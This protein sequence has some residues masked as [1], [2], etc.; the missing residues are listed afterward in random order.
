MDLR[1]LEYFQMVCRLNNMT[2]A[3][4]RLYVAQP[5]ISVAIHKLEVEMGVQ[6]FERSQKQFTL[7]AEGRIFLQRAEDILHRSQ[8]LLLE[9]NEYRELKKGVVKLGVPPM[10]G[11]Y[12]FPRIF[13]GFKQAYPAL[14]LTVIEEGSL[15]VRSM[16]EK[17]KLDLGIVI[18]S[19]LSGL[20]NIKPITTGE[21][22]LCLAPSHPFATCSAVNFAQLI[23]ESFILLKE[24]TYHRQLILQECKTHGFQPHI[25]LASSQVETIRGL[26]AKGVGISFLLD[27][28]AR[29]DNQIHCLPLA[30]P[31]YIE[32]GLVWKKDRYLSK[33]SQAFIDF[34]STVASEP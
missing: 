21:I 5:A 11:C 9:M 31:L 3:A 19:H 1:Q 16:L 24:D 33:A 22:L 29:R 13:A 28:I 25:I 17:D 12:L 14:D 32:I 8:D 27:S 7:T 18:T 2:R 20:L 34:I 30:D 4:E 10:I 15:A 6:L 26:V 23:N